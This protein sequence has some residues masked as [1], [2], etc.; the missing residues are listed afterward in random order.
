MLFLPFLSSPPE[1]SGLSLAVHFLQEAFLITQ[2]HARAMFQL[3]SPL[4]V[5]DLNSST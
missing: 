3:G 5:L 4:P 2:D 1:G